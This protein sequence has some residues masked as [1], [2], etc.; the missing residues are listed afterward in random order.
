MKQKFLETLISKRNSTLRRWIIN[1]FLVI[2]VI[3]VGILLASA[4]LLRSYYYDSARQY[5]NSRMNTV[6]GLL[7]RSY[8]D[9]R[10]NYSA[11]VR[12]TVVNW[13]EAGR[14]ELFAVGQN[15][16]LVTSSGFAPGYD[17]NTKD[18]KDA[19]SGQS[20]YGYFTGRLS[21]GEN[22]VAVSL[23]LPD[24]SG[25]FT[26]MR[27]MSSLSNIDRQVDGIIMAMIIVSACV[28]FLIA[29]SGMYFVRSIVVPVKSLAVMAGRYAK[30]D[31]SVRIAKK[32]DDEIGELCDVI[33][34]MAEDLQTADSIKNE[35]ISSVSHELRT[36]LTAIK[37]WSETIESFPDDRETIGKG[38]HVIRIETERLSQMVE[39]L[40]DFS[41]MQNG[42]FSLSPAKMDI[43][44]ELGEAVLIYTER[45]RQEGK[46][47]SYEEP[48]M[49]P[50]IIG[51]KNRL[52]QVFIN[53]IDNA[54]K[55]TDPGGEITVVAGMADENTIEIEVSD[56]GVGIAAADLPRIK[57]KFFKP[58]H[59]RRG[60]GIGLAVA[61]E[62]I[63]MHGGNID[64]ASELGKGTTVSVKLPI[65]YLTK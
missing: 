9:A 26:A 11:E 17:L 14:I 24:N 8:S 45:A 40:L 4:I 25:G 32:T 13:T 19:L 49:L 22:V 42:K 33:N 52:R 50:F 6:A 1:N 65:V 3:L 46:M 41:R 54:V 31:F 58:N 28:M 20:G 60:S 53:I 7:S 30:G 36:P 59:T 64:I 55:Y 34:K 29:V 47:L 12:N 38:M 16:T 51:D 48:D 56:T 10:D 21:S 35:F 2:F 27:M 23:R 63:A 62:I 61:D 15:N 5:I 18:L 43:L 57:T 37:G 39:E 44:A